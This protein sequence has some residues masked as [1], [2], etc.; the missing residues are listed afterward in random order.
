MTIRDND[1]FSIGSAASGVNIKV[2][3]DDIMDDTEITS[4]IDQAIKYYNKAMVASRR[5]K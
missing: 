5:M 2:F 4:K 3:F 1:S